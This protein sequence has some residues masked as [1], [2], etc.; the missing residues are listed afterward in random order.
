MYNR[1]EN[2]TEFLLSDQNTAGGSVVSA[3]WNGW[4]QVRD[5]P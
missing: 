5:G 2:K 3:P 1:T 4:S